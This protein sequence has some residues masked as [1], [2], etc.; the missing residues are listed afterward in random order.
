MAAQTYAPPPI[1]ADSWQTTPGSNELTPETIVT[2]LF[3]GGPQI[4]DKWDGIDHVVPPN[5]KLPAGHK[6]GDLLPACVGTMPYALAKH[7]RQRAIV[8]GTK[9]PHPEHGGKAISQLAILDAQFRLDKRENCEPLPDDLLARF[10]KGIEA[11][12][13]SQ[14]ESASLRD[15][16]MVDP[17]AAL[18]ALAAQGVD[19]NTDFSIPAGAL[20]RPE[21]HAGLAEVAEAEAAF[22]DAQASG[23]VGRDERV[24]RTVAAGGRRR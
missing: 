22:A 13:R 18:T 10:G 12:D 6:P 19:V 1:Q 14:Y 5:D 7:L 11:I 8:P 16:R 4:R 3:R 2:V 20:D 21:G 24:S 9:S 15:V 23:Q 17:R